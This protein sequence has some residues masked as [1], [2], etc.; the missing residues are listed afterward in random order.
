MENLIYLASLPS[1]DGLGSENIIPKET[2]D[3]VTSLLSPEGLTTIIIPVVIGLIVLKFLLSQVGCLV[4]FIIHAASGFACL[5]LVNT[6]AVYTGITIEINLVTVLIAGFLGIPG[7]I[8]LVVK[9]F[10]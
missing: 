1:L 5:W 4:K 7:I 2:I 6:A 9:Q 8:Y 10:L 3:Q